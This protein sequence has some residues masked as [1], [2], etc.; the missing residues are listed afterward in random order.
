MPKKMQP[1]DGLG[2]K[3]I[4][5]IRSALRQVWQR[6]KAWKVV[7]Q[8]CTSIYGWLHCEKC[9]EKVPQIF[10]DHIEKCGTPLDPGYIERLMVPSSK[11]QGLCKKCH[12]AKTKQERAAN[13]DLH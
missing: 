5:K 12:N 13:E 7:K 10:V 3:E 11:L 4:S 6:S 1:T 2:P 9:Q 8:R